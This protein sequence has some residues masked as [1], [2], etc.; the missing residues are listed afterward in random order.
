MTKCVF[1]RSLEAVVALLAVALIGGC[2]YYNTFFNARKAFD[3]AESQRRK[4]GQS[5]QPGYTTAIEKSLKVVDFSPNSKWYD[6]ALYVLG[7][8]YFH[9]GQFYKAERRFRELM[10]NYP[11]AKYAKESNLYLAK[12]KLELG[13]LKE[14][15]EIFDEIFQ[16]GY[17]RQTKAEAAMALGRYHNDLKDYTEAERYFMAVRDSLGNEIERREAQRFV[18]D[19]YFTAFRFQDALSAYLQLLGMK[20]EKSDRYLALYR[21]AVCSYRLQR[22]AVGQDYLKTLAEDQLYYD[23][24][25]VLQLT[26]AEGY[27][28]TG[29]LDQAEYTYNEVAT[30]TNNKNWEAKAYYRLGLIYQYDYDDLRSAKRYYDKASRASSFVEE[31]KD[32]I[33]RSTDI[34]KLD[35]F[36]IEY[37]RDTSATADTSLAIE[38]L[39]ERVNSAARTQYMLAELYWFQLNKPD[40][41]INELRYL[42]DRF[43][44]SQIA[45]KAII[46]LSQMYRDY[47]ADTVVADSILRSVPAKYPRS[48]FVPVANELLGLKGTESDTGYAQQYFARAENFL[49]DTKNVDSARYYYQYVADSFP[50]SDLNVRARYNLIWVKENYESPGDSSV[51]KAYRQFVDS[52]PAAPQAREITAR[53]NRID[54]L[55]RQKP[56]EKKEESGGSPQDSGAVGFSDTL[57]QQTPDTTFGLSG[58]TGKL[59]SLYAGPKGEKLILLELF[60]IE[61]QVPFEFP[62][63]AYNQ[64]QTEYTCAFQILLDYSGRVIDDIL[65][66][67]SGN[68]EIDR[69]ADL[70]IRS[71]TFNP[72]DVSGQESRKAAGLENEPSTVDPRGKWY[73]YK[74][75]IQ[76]PKQLR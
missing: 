11:T 31:G 72:A 64:P 40:S 59:E 55:V 23:S 58:L 76:K 8:S 15:I 34:S 56:K 3:S 50:E 16:A 26:L 29:D 13:E 1:A 36:A 35:T 5:K 46:A 52:F 45:P 42:I 51:I 20:L 43:P 47:L 4:T 65:K 33:Q 30:R 60:P 25:G 10:T 28:Y 22:I 24:L 32:A 2:V 62:P 71:M 39:K 54:A 66:Q 74:Y 18:A 9:T 12:T 68:S 70:T 41:A 49:V 21:A 69:R 48:D 63:E 73:V 14:A 19:N 61:T 38:K 17:D 75:V 53:L 7:V 27:E 37:L 6:D 44:Q 57:A 67:P